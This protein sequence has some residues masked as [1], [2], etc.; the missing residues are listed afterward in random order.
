MK[1]LMVL[2]LFL[3]FPALLQ[4]VVTALRH[5]TSGGAVWTVIQHPSNYT[6]T[7]P[8][9][10]STQTMACTVTATP[11]TAGNAILLLSSIFGASTVAP[12]FTSAT[13]D[14]TWTHCPSAYATAS[15]T[16]GRETTDCA[17]VLSATGGGTS[18]VFT[19][20][21]TGVSSSHYFM[22]VE[23]IEVHRSVGTSTLDASNGSTASNAATRVG[24]VCSLSSTSDYV[25]QWIAETESVTAISGASYTNPFDLDS[26]NVVAGFAGALNQSSAPAQTWT[27][28]G[29][30]SGDVAAM[31]CVAL[32]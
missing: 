22:D 10:G 21:G 23:L 29:D 4:E 6:C 1:A 11:I 30:A 14:S 17:Y 12:T 9:T 26:T 27:T 31:S 5:P 15:N 20:T 2:A 8:T 19:W 32:R 3:S 16:L 28:A 25:A 7:A 24:P 13:G 18:F